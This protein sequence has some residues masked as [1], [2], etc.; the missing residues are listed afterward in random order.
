[1][2]F[3]REIRDI[4]NAAETVFAF[5]SQSIN[6]MTWIPRGPIKS[7]RAVK[8]SIAFGWANNRHEC[9]PH[10]PQALGQYV[11]QTGI[12]HASYMGRHQYSSP[13]AQGFHQGSIHIQPVLIFGPLSSPER[14]LILV[15]SSPSH[16]VSHTLIFFSCSYV[17]KNWRDG[18]KE[19]RQ[20]E[21]ML[22]LDRM[23]GSLR[24]FFTSAQR[25]PLLPRSALL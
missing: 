2:S 7:K 16:S 6:Y 4:F 9:L 22:L 12:R 20:D 5:L 25:L 10:L 18:V 14:T 23:R 13:H 21:W 15:S 3:P 24:S 19:H 1:M 8:L 11:A 17:R